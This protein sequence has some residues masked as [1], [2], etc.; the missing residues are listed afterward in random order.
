MSYTDIFGS[1]TVPPSDYSLASYSLVDAT[2]QLYWPT[3]TP[4]GAKYIAKIT[5]LSSTVP[6]AVQLQSAQALSVGF[7][8]I[9]EN[10]GAQ[11]ITVLD[12]DGLSM[13]AVAPGSLVY[14]YLVDNTS[15][16]GTWNSTVYG[17]GTSQVQASTLAGTGLGVES[18]KLF[19]RVLSETLTSNYTVASADNAKL[20]VVASGTVTLTLPALASLPEGFYFYFKNSATSAAT[21][22]PSDASTIEGGTTKTF[23]PD[24]AALVMAA[25]L[26]WVTVG[27]GR[28]VEFV[29]SEF[30]INAAAPDPTLT[31]GD[32]SGR[33]LRV[34]GTATSSK[35]VTLPP[36][37]GVYFVTTDG[38]LGSYSVTF[39][40]G[41]GTTVALPAN[42]ATVLYC[43]GTNVRIAIST[44]VQSTLSLVDG[45]AA[46][47][48]L[49]WAINADTGFYRAA[50]NSVGFSANGVAVGTL[51][52]AGWTGPAAI[53][54]GSITGITDLAVADGGTGASDAAAARTN[55][56]AA[57]SALNLTAGNG[58][59]GG[60]SLTG[61]R[62]F[63]LGTPAT[64]TV[65][66]INEA[67]ADSHTHAVTFPVTSVAGKTG[68]V[69][70][71]KADVGLTNVADA[72]TTNASN[73]SSGTLA[74]A[75]TTGTSAN[76]ASTLVLR[77]ASGEISTGNISCTGTVTAT[78]N[79]TLSS[80]V[81]LKEDIGTL[82]GS[83]SL[84]KVM[85]MRPV[86]YR[87]KGFEKR[88]V[89]L[90]AQEVSA[91]VPEVVHSDNESGYLSLEYQNLV[92][93][94]IAAIQEQQTQIDALKARV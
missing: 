48:S 54:A 6:A 51:S 56:G 39:T 88:C 45:S 27:Y 41:A 67:T 49:Y 13:L 53:N 35:T 22:D 58:L 90:I 52:S 89:G 8:F 9:I 7:D 81:R 43:D 46:A 71:V 44:S 72:D 12:A 92:A 38:G 86:G 84:R 5:R 11:V 21:L 68:A 76:T 37:P 29:F 10:A 77:G 75:R 4:V 60:G 57:A 78:V 30:V 42:Q 3:A 31:T 83:D 26:G 70:L 16:A 87:L 18:N 47:P 55:L 40:I 82:S 32:V 33:M 73:I 17:A 59:T 65:S 61:D 23:A 63:A 15:T 62:D 20:L 64:L 74:N 1:Q 24:E 80:D 25:P 94:L 79:L 93:V 2:T 50:T 36:V 14:V 91:I 28:D 34:T 66:T 85:Q 19:V 69:T